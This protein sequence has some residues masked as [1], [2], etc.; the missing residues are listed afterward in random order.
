M[1]APVGRCIAVAALASGMAMSSSATSAWQ[2]YEQKDPLTGAIYSRLSERSVGTFAIAGIAAGTPE[3]GMECDPGDNGRRILRVDVTFPVAIS[4]ETF[5]VIDY[6]FD[7]RPL[8]SFTVTVLRPWQR[9]N[10]LSHSFEFLQPMLVA[11]RVRMEFEFRRRG[12]PFL[13]FD[14]SDR[15]TLKT[16]VRACYADIDMVPPE[17]APRVAEYLLEE[18]SGSVQALQAAL[19]H[20]QLFAG[21]ADGRRTPALFLALQRYA[22]ERQADEV[23]NGEIEHLVR[24]TLFHILSG[25]S[26]IP[27]DIRKQL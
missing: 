11:N 8:E 14:L 9:L 24:R 23:A 16:F 17:V 13:N 25:D 22:V 3:L 5:V 1:R 6:Q 20:L 27:A 4:R 26:R 19:K 15:D 7:D 12:S 10:F 2:E 18:A 21:E